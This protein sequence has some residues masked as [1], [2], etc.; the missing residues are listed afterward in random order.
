MRV[1]RPGREVQAVTAPNP[2]RPPLDVAEKVRAYAL[3]PTRSEMEV[4][5][6]SLAP[7]ILAVLKRAEEVAGQSCEF[8][9]AMVDDLGEERD[10]GREP[11]AHW[12]A[13][14]RCWNAG[15]EE[16]SAAIGHL[17]DLLDRALEE[18]EGLWTEVKRT[19]RFSRSR[20]PD[21]DYVVQYG[22]GIKPSE[23]PF[24]TA[25]LR[26]AREAEEGSGGA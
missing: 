11:H 20:G 8:C 13:C 16:T 3:N 24:I 12:W 7:A 9:D 23:V 4:W 14:G 6:Q 26:A 5:W 21:R 10:G 19:L 1:P 22:S 25:I 18:R 15:A 2:E 17:S